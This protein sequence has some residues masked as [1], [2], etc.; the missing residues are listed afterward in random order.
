MYQPCDFNGFVANDETKKQLCQLLLYG[1][2][3]MAVLIVEGRTLQFVTTDGEVRLCFVTGLAT[4]LSIP[5]SFCFH[6]IQLIEAQVVVQYLPTIY[7]N[8]ERLIRGWYSTF[9]MPCPWI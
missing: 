4:A 2:V 5:I 9:I 8:Q 1:V 6:H 3:K 7:N